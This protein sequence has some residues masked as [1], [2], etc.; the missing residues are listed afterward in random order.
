MATAPPSPRYEPSPGLV[1]SDPL[2]V[3]LLF[4]RYYT[5]TDWWNIPGV[6]STYWR[7]YVNGADGCAARLAD[8]SV[9]PL[10]AGAV[11]FIPAWV[12]VD[13]LIGSTPVPH[14]WAHFDLVGC[15]GTLI[16]TLFP[17]P[18]SLPLDPVL[19]ATSDHLR[20]LLVEV[21]ARN[22]ADVLLAA[23]GAVE[24]ALARLLTTLP[25]ID[26][27][28]MTT[29]ATAGAPLEPA[30]THIERHLAQPLPIRALA[31]RCGFSVDHFIRVFRREVG[32]TPAQYVLERRVALAGQRLV[33]TQEP[34]EAI[35][36][37]CGF[38]DRFY[39]TR[40]FRRRVGVPPAAYRQA[41][42]STRG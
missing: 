2:L 26:L 35:A 19:R 16:R 10:P 14:L 38:P 4:A 6:C 9:Y 29:L 8:G 27:A 30:L 22:R 25:A 40:V 31:Q 5:L 13:L 23:K 21:G 3:R 28:R 18:C 1:D 20:H 7:Y 24:V 41:H 15:P 39:F 37:A 36:Q 12:P 32:Q 17:R 42:A 11:H 34:I 33:L